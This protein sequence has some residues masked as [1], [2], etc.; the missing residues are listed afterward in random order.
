MGFLIPQCYASP[1]KDWVS[2]TG[3]NDPSNVWLYELHACDEDT[4]SYAMA[5]IPSETYCGWLELTHTAL[6]CDKIHYYLYPTFRREYMTDMVIEV[7]I[8][9][10]WTEIFQGLPVFAEWVEKS[11]SE[12]S[13]T[14]VRFKFYNSYSG[15]IGVQMCEVDFWG[16][17][18]PPG[19][20][21]LDQN[22]NSLTGWTIHPADSGTAEIDPAGQLHILWQSGG[23]KSYKRVYKDI[24]SLPTEYTVEFSLKIDV[25]GCHHRRFYD[26]VRYVAFW[27]YSDKIALQKEDATKEEYTHETDSNWHTWRLLINASAP[28]L[29]VYKDSNFIHEFTDFKA[30]ASSDGMVEVWVGSLDNQAEIHEDYFKIRTGLHP[31][32]E[33]KQWY[34]IASWNFNLIAKEWGAVSS[35]TFS[36]IVK[37]WS[38]VVSWSFDLITKQWKNVASWSFQLVTKMWRTVSIWVFNVIRLKW[39]DIISWVFNLESSKIAI[40]FIGLVFLIVFLALI[41]YLAYRKKGD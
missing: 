38:Y 26:G 30:Y 19:W 5:I 41:G 6:S 31:P 36:L 28:S 35:W 7:E 34:G 1:A 9:S 13:V 8:Q 37:Q 32:E 15:S 18:P 39:H 12:D 3:Y 20:D 23:S 4:G 2:P 14:G 11:F 16:E 17:I 24:G 21:L 22:W 10:V 29:K 25:F 40:L 27:I 33:E